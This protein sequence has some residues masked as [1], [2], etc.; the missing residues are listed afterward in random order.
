M[1]DN[2]N[3]NDSKDLKGTDFQNELKKVLKDFE[4]RDAQKKMMERVKEAIEYN[5]HLMIEAGTGTGKSLAYLFPA[6][7]RVLSDTYPIVISTA[8]IALQEQLINKEIPLINMLWSDKIKAALIKGRSNFLCLDKYYDKCKE[9]TLI[10]PLETGVLKDWLS[11]TKTG[12]WQEIEGKISSEHWQQLSSNSEACLGYKCFHYKDCFVNK[13]K[14]EGANAHILITNHH[15]YFSDLKLK[16]ESGG[17]IGVLPEYKYVIFDEAHHIE[18]RAMFAFGVQVQKGTI[19]YW[20]NEL[21]SLLGKEPDFKNELSL[22]LERQVYKLFND[23]AKDYY[24][25]YLLEEGL[26]PGFNELSKTLQKTAHYVEAF[27]NRDELNPDKIE[28]LSNAIRKLQD[29]LDFILDTSKENYVSW[30]EVNR[31]ANNCILHSNPIDVS[32]HLNEYLY[33]NVGACI[34]TS[35]TLTVG[36]KF[37]YLKRKLGLC[38]CRSHLI[39]SPF[40]YS[41]QSVIFIPR[42]F[43]IP[44]EDGYKEALVDGVIKLI[45]LSYGRA[46]I[47]FTSYRMMEYVY[48]EIKDKLNYRLLKQGER[49]KNELLSIFQEDVSSVLLATDS[50]REGIDVRG[51]AL[52]LLVM[53]KLPFSVPDEPLIKARIDYLEKRGEN[54]FLKYNLPEAVLKLKQGFGRLIRHRNDKGIFAIFDSR[55]YKKSYGKLFLDSLPPSILYD[56]WEDIEL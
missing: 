50:F 12:E 20:N 37:D 15:L 41:Q 48:K 26:P 19:L 28:N 40:D 53:D 6:V 33:G 42:D 16:V 24:K 8:T 11:K 36:G 49:S 10:D 39:S 35:A 21:K 3:S 7:E 5:N 17:S 44:V 34:F 13:R 29:S 30:V 46:L 55:V 47:L 31:K 27:L 25:S 1:E 56:K 4:F 45:E 52:T 51:E 54:S 32:W 18:E 14:R 43:P 22:K 38:E 9:D 23:L 2:L